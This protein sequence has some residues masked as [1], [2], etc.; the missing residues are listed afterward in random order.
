MGI[1]IY[2][3]PFNVRSWHGADIGSFNNMNSIEVY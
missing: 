3:S 2:F 1:Y